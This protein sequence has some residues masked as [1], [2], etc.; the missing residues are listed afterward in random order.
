MNRIVAKQWLWHTEED[1]EAESLLTKVWRL[2]RAGVG[3]AY[4]HGPHE[5]CIIAG[6]P[7]NQLILFY[8]HL[9]M[10]KRDFS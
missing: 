1:L 9:T 5:L 2:L 4:Y 10:R 7:Q 6:G 8:I 3:S